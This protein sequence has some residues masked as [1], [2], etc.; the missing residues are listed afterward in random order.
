MTVQADINR[1]DQF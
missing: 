1:Q